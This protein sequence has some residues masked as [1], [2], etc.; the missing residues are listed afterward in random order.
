MQFIKR[1]PREVRVVRLYVLTLLGLV[2]LA[3]G[4]ASCG[5]G[6]DDQATKPREEHV[7]KPREGDVSRPKEDD[8]TQSREE[9]VDHGKRPCT[10]PAPFYDDYHP[11]HFVNWTPD[12]TQVIFD[13]VET[14][15]MVDAEGSQL[16]AL[17]EANSSHG[18]SYGFYADVSPQGTQIVYSYCQI[19][20]PDSYKYEIA[21]INLDGT[22]RQRLTENEGPS[23]SPAW[24][25]DGSRIAFLA[26]MYSWERLKLS[27]AELYTMAADGMDKQKVVALDMLREGLDESGYIKGALFAPP[28]WSPDGQRLAF[29]LV[30]GNREAHYKNLYTVRTD[31]TELTRIAPAVVPPVW[32]PNGE[33]LAFVIAH[34]AEFGRVYSRSGGVYTVRPDGTDMRQVLAPPSEAW[35]VTQVAWSPDGSELLIVAGQQLHIFQPDGSGLRTLD[36]SDLYPHYAGSLKFAAWS[37]DGA[38]IAFYYRPDRMSLFNPPFIYTVARDG[39]DRRSLIHAAG[40]YLVAAN[41]DWTDASA[42]IAACSEGFVVS[43]P[44]E[45]PGLVQDC[46]TLLTMRERLSGWRILNWR[47]NVPIT[48]WEGVEIGGVPLRVVR[49]AQ[50]STGPIQGFTGSNFPH[51]IPP[52]IGNLTHLEE[53]H[54]TGF[55]GSIP[56]ELGSLVNLRVLG[57]SQGNL[58]SI[59][60]ELGNL[61]NLQVLSLVNN[62]LGGSIP[63][64]LGK[65][66]NL[67][68]IDLY[69]NRLEG[70][71]PPE[72][73]E[74]ANL[75][76]LR[77]SENSLAGS[78]P[79]EL[80]KLVS[81]QKLYLERNRLTGAIPPELVRLSNLQRLNLLENNLSGCVPADFPERWVGASGL[82]RCEAEN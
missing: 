8:V 64:A 81:L 80:G 56:A 34:E 62:K 41:S 31:G 6:L 17:V 38:R 61:T 35:E 42:D 20:P 73:G 14:I 11:H 74:L 37:P 22:G 23:N 45:N 30:E 78:I 43:Q 9:V 60:P 16:E 65:L 44:Q 51:V 29:L 71:I 77:L 28:A 10:G 82:E 5:P 25:P 50:G 21:V 49:L 67:Q 13:H 68:E 76:V 2:A 27:G 53:I 33:H 24:S 32:S 52:E 1:D 54:L 26:N 69:G 79:P 57:M 19:L 48:A 66:T 39:T 47:A 59:P 18:F 36:L 46:Q 12:G 75:E 70:G 40:T 15:Y 3:L 58:E 55:Q 63:P 4:I 7:T 72:L